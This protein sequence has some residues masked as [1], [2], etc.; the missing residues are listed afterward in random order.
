MMAAFSNSSSVA[1]CFWLMGEAEMGG[2]AVVNRY[3]HH[4]LIWACYILLNREKINYS[5]EASVGV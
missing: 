2:T 3:I 1:L 4:E 5:Q